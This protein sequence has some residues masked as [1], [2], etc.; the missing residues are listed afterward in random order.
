LNKFSLKSGVSN[1]LIIL[2]FYLPA[3]ADDPDVVKFTVLQMNDVY[4]MQR[5]ANESLGGLSRVAALRNRLL[6]ENPNTISVLSGD[7][8]SPSAINGVLIDG[9]ENAGRTMVMVLNS[10]K[11]DYATFGNHEFDLSEPQFLKRISESKFRWISSN[12]LNRD[13]KHFPA[14][15]PNE[16]ITFRGIGET[17]VRVGL[18]GVTINSNNPK[19]V[20]FRDPLLEMRDQIA[21]L[22]GKCDV[23]IALTH[24]NIET[25]R[26]IAQ[27]VPG[28]HLILGG[29][30]HVHNYEIRYLS[31]QYLPPISKAD[32]NARTVY[33]H[34][35][36]FSVKTRKLEIRSQLH[37]VQGLPADADQPEA[38]PDDVDPTT[39]RLIRRLTTLAY[40]AL[41]TS[42]GVNPDDILAQS[43]F[44]LDGRDSSVRY[45]ST[46][47]TRL[48]AQAY[49]YQCRE[50][51]P[52]AVIYNCGSIRIDEVIDAGPIRVVDV[53]RALPYKAK[54]LTVSMEGGLLLDLLSTGAR[55]PGKGGFLQ[56]AGVSIDSTGRWVID[57]E[58]ISADFR[59]PIVL[60]DY[61]L[62]GLENGYGDSANPV[63]I[64]GRLLSIWNSLPP[65]VKTLNPDLSLEE[66]ESRRAV[67]D[68]LK[69]H[70]QIANPPDSDIDELQFP[71]E[72][73]DHPAIRMH[74]DSIS[75]PS[76]AH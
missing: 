4:L 36:T 35:L 43:E 52:R 34:R 53:F 33:I 56:Y 64:N 60:N 13:G 28:V 55:M 62:R 23:I 44:P 6:Q 10:M 61:L 12:V 17:Q 7:F 15:Q 3:Q 42:Y 27:E 72:P 31:N 71:S 11:L 29:H 70:P 54:L 22:H 57:G 63:S 5:P 2:F 8:L 1:L 16:I 47:L 69:N 37:P 67:I 76:R 18:I 66:F 40:S 32:A 48:L 9:E 51:R 74:V 20:S 14:V 75:R 21:T 59:Y 41:K 38:M 68:F 45:R 46:N 25:D 49:L 50:S 58:P 26:R 73:V 19:Y 65:E 24:L 39:E 30:E